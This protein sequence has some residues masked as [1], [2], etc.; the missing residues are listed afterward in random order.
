MRIP[1]IRI[2]NKRTGKVVKINEHEWAGDLGQRKWAGW[3]RA[4]GEQ[5]GNAT[6]EQEKE[7]ADT[8]IK[9]EI[10]KIERERM[11]LEVKTEDK[12]K[13]GRP[14]KI[15]NEEPISLD[16]FNDMKLK[17]NNKIPASAFSE[18]GESEA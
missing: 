15:E 14:K 7:I 16:E 12:P 8:L 3:E 13:R 18:E 1:T 9:E 17:D 4:G 5:H 2:R 11:P 6:P 10:K